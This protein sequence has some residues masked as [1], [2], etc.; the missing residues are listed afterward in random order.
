MKDRYTVYESIKLHVIMDEYLGNQVL[1][2]EFTS[3]I[4]YF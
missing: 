4:L 2:L 1:I 3:H